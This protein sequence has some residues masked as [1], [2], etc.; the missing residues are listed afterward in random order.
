MAKVLCVL[1]DDPKSGYP[2]SYARDDIPTITS[3]PGGQSTPT[4]QAIAQPSSWPSPP[5]S[6]RTM[7]TWPPRPSTA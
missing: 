1:Y 7:S 4:P 5:A 2:T 3:Y 6:D